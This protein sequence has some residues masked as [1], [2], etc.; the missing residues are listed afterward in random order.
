[1][2]RETF[3]SKVDRWL[4]L[5]LGAAGILAVVAV[6]AAFQTGEMPLLAALAILLFAVGLP[7]WILATTRYDLSNELLVVRS[8][9]F[10]WRIPLSEI[11]SVATTR[12]PLSSPALSLDRLRLEYGKG[13]ALMISPR[14]K[15]EFLRALAARRKP[16]T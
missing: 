8:G 15:D 2:P 9:P 14:D 11:T 7:T 10:R 1:M 3:R 6:G 4:V 16:S 5:V 12:N 13:R